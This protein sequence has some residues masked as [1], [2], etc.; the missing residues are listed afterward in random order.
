MKIIRSKVLGF[1]MGVERAV[2]FANAES[3]RRK[4]I[5]SFGSLVHSS[6]VLSDLRKNGIKDMEEL[7]RNLEDCSVIIRA[8]GI[9]PLEE[10]DLR[11]RGA[12]VVDAT[13]PIVKAS[14]MHAEDLARA[15]YSIFLAG[16][17]KH[18]EI[19]GI[20][21]YAHNTASASCILVSGA[22]E[23]GRAAKK[24][25]C[26]KNDS[27]TALLG[28]TTIDEDEYGAIG[29]AIKLFFPNLEIFQTICSATSIRQNALRD[30]IEQTEAVIIIGG[31]ESANTRRLFAV[32]GGSGKPCILAEDVS[33]IPDSFFSYGTVGISAGASTPDYLI[34]EFEKEL[35]RH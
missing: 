17:A 10:K 23:A 1:C 15:G 12:H 16:E 22:F 19:E 24:L 27:K 3:K 25:Y 32:A 31:S 2:E 8:H 9:T 21:G 29:E 14:Q 33:E 30:L 26:I 6:R 11:A 4:H 5:Y 20:A 35:L 18:A 28:Q 13:C 34:D 7:P